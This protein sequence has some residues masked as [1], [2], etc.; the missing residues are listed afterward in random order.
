M[1]DGEKE[2][3]DNSDIKRK[4]LKD[5]G[6]PL[7]VMAVSLVIVFITWAGFGYIGPSF[8]NDILIDQQV[9]LREKYNMPPMETVSETESE[10]PPS[11]RHAFKNDTTKNTSSTT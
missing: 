7:V 11:L 8:S 9:L 5:Y 1:S 2:L 3:P 6:L 4:K 10:I